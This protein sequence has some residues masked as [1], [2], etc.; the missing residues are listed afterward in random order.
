MRAIT[1]RA[2]LSTITA[3]GLAAVLTTSVQARPTY[4]MREGYYYADRKTGG[5]RTSSQWD[6]YVGLWFDTN[7]CNGEYACNDTT[8][9]CVIP[10]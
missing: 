1:K 10:E 5:D 4:C 2:I 8:I 6:Y 3:A 7:D 9:A